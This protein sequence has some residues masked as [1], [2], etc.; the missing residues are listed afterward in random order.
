MNTAQLRFMIPPDRRESFMA[1]MDRTLVII[2]IFL[3]YGCIDS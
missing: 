3:G 2:A 1:S